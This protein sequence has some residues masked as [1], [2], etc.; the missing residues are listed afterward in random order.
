MTV[1]FDGS[2]N[3]KLPDESFSLDD[4]ENTL[5]LGSDG[6]SIDDESAANLSLDDDEDGGDDHED[7]A[8]RPTTE[9]VDEDSVGIGYPLVGFVCFA[10]VVFNGCVMFGLIQDLSLKGGISYGKNFFSSIIDG[11]LVLRFTRI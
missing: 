4:D 8:F 7:V 10:V 11:D 6:L 2:D 9:I 1:D 3:L 5:N